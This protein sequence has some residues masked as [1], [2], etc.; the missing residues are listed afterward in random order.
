M[1]RE[2]SKPTSG[3]ATCFMLYGLLRV[4]NIAMKEFTSTES[5]SCSNA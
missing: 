2:K 1:M 5:A 3:A 4:S